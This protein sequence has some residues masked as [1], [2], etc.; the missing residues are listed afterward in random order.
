V[1]VK[2]DQYSLPEVVGHKSVLQSGGQVVSVPTRPQ[3]S[4]TALIEK[5]RKVPLRKRSAA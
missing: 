3:Y 4:T 1:L 2:A 5:I